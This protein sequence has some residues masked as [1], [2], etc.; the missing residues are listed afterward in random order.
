MV[1]NKGRWRTILCADCGKSVVTRSPRTLRC[2]SCQI[3]RVAQSTLLRN[4]ARRKKHK[5]QHL[6]MDCGEPCEHYH[7]TTCASARNEEID[8]GPEP[9]HIDAIWNGRPYRYGA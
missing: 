9:F 5:E 1:I 4:R 7:C 2:I 3:Q 8:L 6:C